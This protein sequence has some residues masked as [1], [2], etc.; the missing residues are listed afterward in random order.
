MSAKRYSARLAAAAQRLAA[1]GVDALVVAPSPDLSYLLGYDPMPMERPTLLIVTRNEA[2]AL[3][4]P[5]LERPLAEGCPAAAALRIVDWRD[6][7]D[8]YGSAARLLPTGGAVALGDRIWGVHVL[9]LQTAVLGTTWTSGA[10]IVGVL[11]S[12]K[13]EH[14]V[15][16]LRRA[17]AAA[18][19]T[20]ADI[21]AMPF[22]GRSELDV[23]ADLARLL[24]AHGHARADFTIVGSGPNA[25]S[26]HHE[27]TART[28]APGDAVV[29]DFGGV[30][31]GYYSDTTRT[32]AVGEPSAELAEVH[33]VV[34]RA[35]AAATAVI[36]PGIEIR[37]VDRAARAVIDEAGYGREFFHR[38]GHGIGMEIH[39][40]PYAAEEDATVLEQGMTFSVEPGIYLDRRLGVRIED[41]VCVTADGV[42]PLNRSPRELLVVT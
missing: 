8:P 34:R 27:P 19:A 22:A 23:A 14:E 40:P 24:V 41:I 20:F 15:D 31:D 9:G 32:V 39:E 42:E 35:Q 10:P 36:R 17:G 37:E 1:V 11:R 6:G 12:R 3:L 18:D 38:T 2:P 33:A 5:T 29:L 28:I 4:V 30:L 7:Q 26:P 25:A 21:A 13:D 16:A